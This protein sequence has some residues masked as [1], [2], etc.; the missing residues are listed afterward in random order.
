[1]QINKSQIIEK[2]S[3]IPITQL[4]VY[5]DST[6]MV[7]ENAVL[8]PPPSVED[9]VILPDRDESVYARRYQLESRRYIGC[10]SKL[11]DW[12]FETIIAETHDVHSFCDIFAGTGSVAHHALEFYERVLVNDFLHS[13]NI[14]YQAFFE[15]SG[16]N[17]EYI[18]G[19]LNDFNS[20]N[21][22]T[23]RDNYFSKNFGGK[24]FDVDT[25][26]LVGC[27]RERIKRLRPAL[28]GKEYAILLASLIYSIDRIANT[29]GHF[30]AYIKKEIPK[31]DFKMRLVDARQYEGV[32]IYREDANRLARR[33]HVDVAYID[34]PYN[35]R[36][37]SRFYHVYENLVQWKKPKLFGVAMKPEEENM[38]EYCRKTAV[39]A[40]IDL[41]AH[42]D[43][44]YLVVSYNNTYNSKSS[45]SENKIKLEQ[46]EEI[47][48]RC[49]ETKV[50]MHSHTPF[51]SGKTEFDD[52][53]EYLFISEIDNE[54]RN[55][56][57]APVLRR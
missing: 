50:F 15:N 3:K 14:I 26:K 16:W 31:R 5:S 54:R 8:Q 19:L 49:G 12:I 29:L 36:Q 52:H 13:N 10:K 33:I 30:D 40:F 51:N 4:E 6:P 1:M 42:I 56:S 47:L 9:E 25:A 57:F 48:N 11:I 44:R 39:N 37:Y 41:V 34:P 38:S 55:R 28:T 53:K 35:S 45:S 2:M 18:I 27:I 17:E 32:E 46:I 21:P 20:I 43:A 22:A 7:L 24:F 23:L